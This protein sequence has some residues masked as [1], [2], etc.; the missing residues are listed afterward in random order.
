MVVRP[1]RAGGRWPAW[2]RV[3]SAPALA[4]GLTLTGVL[5]LAIPPAAPPDVLGDFASA[6][7]SG[8]TPELPVCGDTAGVVESTVVAARPRIGA[9]SIVVVSS[10]CASLALGSRPEP[11]R[12]PP[13]RACSA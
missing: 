2:S 9:M 11:S 8:R 3:G 7:W 4:A 10:G 1:S 12:G 5:Y 13:G 6:S